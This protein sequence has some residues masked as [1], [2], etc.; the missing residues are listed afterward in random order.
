[1]KAEDS[2]PMLGGEEF[3]SLVSHEIKNPL[4]SI[5]GFASFAEDAVRNNDVLSA[6]ESLDVVRSEARRVLKLAEDLLDV[7]CVRAGRFT[8]HVERLDVLA[9]VEPLVK[10]Y[11]TMTTRQI[12]VYAPPQLPH[13]VA[14]PHRLG[15]VMENLISNAVKYSPDSTPIIVSLATG[16]SALRISVSNC[17][18]IPEDKV[19]MLFRRFVRLAVDSDGNGRRNGTGLGLYITRKIVEMHGGSITVTSSDT[20]GTT[21]T[22]EL[23]SEEET[24][25]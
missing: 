17:G 3:L 19:R 18:G 9:I 6:L 25:N 20:E 13:V 5:T 4:T 23:P 1:M 2:S 7:S 8:L 10:R 21:F 14:D 24:P 22:I 11:V 16:S 12:T 15:Q